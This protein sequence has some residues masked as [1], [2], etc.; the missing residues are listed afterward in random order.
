MP[1]VLVPEFKSHADDLRI[2]RWEEAVPSFCAGDNLGDLRSICKICLNYD[3]FADWLA[4]A[5]DYTPYT[6]CTQEKSYDYF[7][8]VDNRHGFNMLRINM[9]TQFK[10]IYTEL[11]RLLRSGRKNEEIETV[12]YRR[13]LSRAVPGADDQP[14]LAQSLYGKHFSGMFFEEA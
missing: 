1:L 14:V 6:L 2:T 10:T 3:S 9:Q 5:N 11:C 12:A 7:T 8:N 13:F 4:H